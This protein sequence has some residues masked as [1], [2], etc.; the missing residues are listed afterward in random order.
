VI[1]GADGAEIVGPDGGL[2]VRPAWVD[3]VAARFGEGGPGPVAD[4]ETAS[5]R[6]LL[7]QA[8]AVDAKPTLPASQSS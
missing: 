6:G 4:V 5:V 3:P 8:Q 2:A 7:E 1:L